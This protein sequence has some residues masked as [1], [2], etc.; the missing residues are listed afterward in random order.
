MVRLD[1]KIKLVVM[2]LPVGKEGIRSD[3]VKMR[4]R[5]LYHLIFSYPHMVAFL[6]LQWDKDC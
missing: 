5:F 3:A 6:A 4:M 1:A 2:L